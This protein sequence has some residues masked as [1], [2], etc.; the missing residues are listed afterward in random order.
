MIDGRGLGDPPYPHAIGTFSPPAVWYGRLAGWPPL[1][2]A[3]WV[4][5]HVYALTRYSALI[6]EDGSDFYW[7]PLSS[8]RPRVPGE[9][10]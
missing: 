5:V 8:L 6:T 2:R 1:E 7:V 10:T 9:A 3:S 4:E